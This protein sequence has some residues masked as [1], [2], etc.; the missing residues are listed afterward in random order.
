ME[1][2][3]SNR[4]RLGQTS[5]IPTIRQQAQGLSRTL[6]SRSNTSKPF[7]AESYPQGLT[8]P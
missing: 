3:N 7:Q 2:G 1:P 6:L 8:D 4:R 5:A